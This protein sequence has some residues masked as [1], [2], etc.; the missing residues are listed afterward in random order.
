MIEPK[1]PVLAAWNLSQPV[2]EP[3]L[4]VL[5]AL[6]LSHWTTRE[7]PLYHMF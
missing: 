3:K 7:V 2:I 5:A 1:P 4:P 6:S